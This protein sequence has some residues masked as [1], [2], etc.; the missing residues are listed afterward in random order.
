MLNKITIKKIIIIIIVLFIMIA[1][2]GIFFG[3]NEKTFKVIENQ[4]PTSQTSTNSI[5]IDTSTPS[6]NDQS[7]LTFTLEIQTKINQEV[8]KLTAGLTTDENKSASQYQQEIA[9][10][11]NKLNLNTSTKNINP[12]NLINIAKELA[13]IKP[14]PIFQQFHLELI[15]LYYGLGYTLQ[16]FQKTDDPVKKILLYNLI[17]ANLDKIKF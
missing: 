6:L 1:L 14:P 13:A 17:K 9:K 7:N 2:I 10:I 12:E 15:K 8:N 4:Q 3:R 16:E 11:Q 5:N